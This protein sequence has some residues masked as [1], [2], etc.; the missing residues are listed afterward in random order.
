MKNY[1]III[2]TLIQFCTFSQNK[3]TIKGDFFGEKNIETSL[4]Y[5]TPQ[6][7]DLIAHNV[8]DSTYLYDMNLNG[9]YIIVFSGKQ[10]DYK[11][12]IGVVES[13][14]I[15]LEIHFE[16]DD[17]PNV[18]I[19]Y[20]EETERYDLHDFTDEETKEILGQLE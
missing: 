5:H 12:F 15:T 10:R 6:G 20:N 9:D 16:Y 3:F 19:V 14:V 18:F 2:V 7:I 11:M 8:F 13:T 4:F 17:K 1:L